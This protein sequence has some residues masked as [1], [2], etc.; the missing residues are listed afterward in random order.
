MNTGRRR[1]AL[2]YIPGLTNNTV[3]Q[4]IIF[5]LGAY[6]VFSFAWA[7]MLLVYQGEANFTQ[8][9]IPEVALPVIAS[10]KAHWWTLFTYGWFQFPHGFLELLSNMVWL[11]CFGYF[12]FL[13][14]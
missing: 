1:S 7:V 9:I 13:N 14:K 2:S 12:D 5:S 11:Y 10:F 6:V 3:M 4:L 8:Y